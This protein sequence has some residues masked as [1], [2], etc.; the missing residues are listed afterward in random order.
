MPG[1]PAL[2]I[3]GEHHMDS[4]FKARSFKGEI[5]PYWRFTSYS[6]LKHNISSEME[7]EPGNDDEIAT[8]KGEDQR[9]NE[10][11]IFNFP[12]GRETGNAW[13]KIFEIIDF[14]ADDTCKV[15]QDV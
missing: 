14:R 10:V 5:P 4:D 8:E 7:I 15:V 1:E 6:G 9:Q 12:K 3:P 2:T 13:H 11:T